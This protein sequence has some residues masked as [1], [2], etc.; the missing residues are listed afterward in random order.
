M[1][2]L[3]AI[4]VIVILAY[5]LW[6]CNCDSKSGF[7]VG[8]VTVMPITT[9]D[10]FFT[11]YKIRCPGD[12]YFGNIVQLQNQENTYRN[13]NNSQFGY[14]FRVKDDPVTRRIYKTKEEAMQAFCADEDRQLH[15]MLY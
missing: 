1:N 8:D 11:Q 2:N 9:E 5:Y 4:L 7:K 14:E 6:T 3:A 13:V 12:K 15:P 10:N